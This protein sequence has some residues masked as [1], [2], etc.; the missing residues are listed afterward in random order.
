MPAR[1]RNIRAPRRTAA[2]RRHRAGALRAVDGED[3]GEASREWRRL[4][5]EFWGALLLVAVAAGGDM[6]VA[7]SGGKVS[8]G[9]AKAAPGLLVMA[10]IYFM[11]SVSGA[12]L[13]PS[14][15]LAFALRGNF[16]WSR[17]PGYVVAQMAGAVAAVLL[18]RALLGTAGCLGA[19]IPDPRIGALRACLIEVLLTAG[20]VNT[21]LGTAAGARQCR[22]QR[23][24][25]G[26]RLHRPGGRHV[27]RAVQRRLDESGPLPWPRHRPWRLRDEL[28]LCARAGDWRRHRGRLRTHPSRAADAA[29]LARA[30]QGDAAAG[31]TG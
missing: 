28:G 16:P 12:H 23:R 22:S 26:G 25:G 14:V 29:R 21:V 10:V 27:G 20:L 2:D 4:F 24:P 5:A 17:V 9:M 6:A 31:P 3:F 11:G 19:T 18:L 1:A 15:S 7:M 30:A 8:F 13:N